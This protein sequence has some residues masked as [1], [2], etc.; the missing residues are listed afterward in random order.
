[1]EL[2]KFAKDWEDAFDV[3]N[4]I[5]NSNSISEAE[6]VF[7]QNNIHPLSLYGLLEFSLINEN[8]LAVKD[9]MSRVLEFV[10]EPL[11]NHY[12]DL[13]TNDPIGEIILKP[14][15]QYPLVL[16]P[17]G[18][19]N[20]Q[21]YLDWMLIGYIYLYRCY[22][23]KG[24]EAYESLRTMG[25]VIERNSDDF[26]FLIFGSYLGLDDYSNAY[27]KYLIFTYL[28][29]GI[30][31]QK[32]GGNND[33]FFQLTNEAKRYAEWLNDRNQPKELAQLIDEGMKIANDL[34]NKILLDIKQGK[35]DISKLTP[36][37][38]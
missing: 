5:L 24:I 30:G 13:P 32:H 1:M 8:K 19:P 18:D 7:S 10:K 26:A 35:I 3:R 11:P 22:Q 15:I 9:C 34:Y 4:D 36:P 6:R 31:Y 23:R 2:Q 14:L 25:V 21:R 29:A 20:I 33:E 28:S 27:T 17:I 37:I 16:S 12:F 38:F